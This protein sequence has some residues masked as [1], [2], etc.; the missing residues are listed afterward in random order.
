MT[1][2]AGLR[3]KVKAERFVPVFG[4]SAICKIRPVF[5]KFR[6]LHSPKP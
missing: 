3:H 6:N 2:I 4:N 5:E 1:R